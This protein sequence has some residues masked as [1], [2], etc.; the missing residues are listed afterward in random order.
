MRSRNWKYNSFQDWESVDVPDKGKI[1]LIGK[2][3]N[4]KV[5]ES[6]EGFL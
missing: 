6:L 4:E 3:L 5:K 2:G 1:V